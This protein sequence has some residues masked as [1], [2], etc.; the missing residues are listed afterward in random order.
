MEAAEH[1]FE[2]RQHE[3]FAEPTLVERVS[4]L[5][6]GNPGFSMLAGLGLGIGLGLLIRGVTPS[7]D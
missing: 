4:T 1:E 7:R 2:Q 5:V 6:R 3:A